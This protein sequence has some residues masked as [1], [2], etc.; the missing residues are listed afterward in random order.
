M[1]PQAL[2]LARTRSARDFAW[3][4]ILLNL[5]G[6]VLLAARSG[7]IREWSFFAVNLVGAAFWALALLVKARH[8]A[9]PRAR[10]G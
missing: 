9:A 7:A 3:S 6:L 5:A 1:L 4:F 8:A 2:R 10:W